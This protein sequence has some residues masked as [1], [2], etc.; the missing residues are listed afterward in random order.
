MNLEALQTQKQAVVKSTSSNKTQKEIKVEDY[1][2][3]KNEGQKPTM[4][5][6]GIEL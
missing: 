2:I 6:Q 1:K 5:T 4:E 3:N